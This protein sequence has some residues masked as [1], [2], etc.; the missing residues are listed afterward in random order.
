MQ[1]QDSFGKGGASGELQ[2][3]PLGLPLRGTAGQLS[4]PVSNMNLVAVFLSFGSC[5]INLAEGNLLLPLLL[6]KPLGFIG[7]SHSCQ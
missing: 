4:E 3:N 6:G 7:F 2:P 5:I 1:R